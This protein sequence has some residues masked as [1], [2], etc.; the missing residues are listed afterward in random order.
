VNANQISC[1]LGQQELEGKRPQPTISGRTLPSFEPYD[2][3]PRAGGFIADR[4]LTGLRPQVLLPLT[5]ILRYGISHADSTSHVISPHTH[6]HA[7]AQKKKKEK[8]W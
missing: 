2:V 5:R 4:F 1:L 8:T 6:M 3:S 7:H